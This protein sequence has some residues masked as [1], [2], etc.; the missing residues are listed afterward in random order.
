M[1]DDNNTT[2][3]N[4]TD[5]QGGTHEDLNQLAG[6]TLESTSYLGNGG[7]VDH[8]TITSYWVFPATATRTRSGLPDLTANTVQPV[9]TWSRQALTDN[10]TTTW[11]IIETDTSYD[12][13][14]T[15]SDFGLPTVQYSHTVPAAAAYERC[16]TTTYA[17]PNTS[18]NLVGLVASCEQRRVATASCVEAAQGVRRLHLYKLVTA[19]LIGEAIYNNYAITPMNFDPG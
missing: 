2:Q 4:L 14:T 17:A 5:S 10:G 9:E 13:T 12:A 8:S 19:E 16:T 3:V 7:P 1:S 15:D 11:R 18:A 6:Q